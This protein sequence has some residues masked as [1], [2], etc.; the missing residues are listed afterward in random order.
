MSKV[1]IE[2]IDIDY[3]DMDEKLDI[4]Q[5]KKEKKRKQRK[6]YNKKKRKEK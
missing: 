5:Q 6:I 1:K 3:Y 2:Q 4:K